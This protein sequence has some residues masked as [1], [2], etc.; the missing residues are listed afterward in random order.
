MRA[1]PRKRRLLPKD[2]PDVMEGVVG[3]FEQCMSFGEVPEAKHVLSL[4][5][6]HGL[7]AKA[8]YDHAMDEMLPRFGPPPTWDEVDPTRWAMEH[9]PMLTPEEMKRLSLAEKRD[10]AK[11]LLQAIVDEGERQIRGEEP[12][13]APQELL[14]VGGRLMEVLAEKRRQAEARQKEPPPKADSRE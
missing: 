2:D 1:K 7:D 5:Q 12:R 13:I 8:I 6:E 4:A 9:L 10:R 11:A 3:L 14:E